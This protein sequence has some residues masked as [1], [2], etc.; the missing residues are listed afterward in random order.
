MVPRFA[1]IE[2]RIIIQKRSKKVEISTKKVLLTHAKILN[3]E[4]FY[5]T[6]ILDNILTNAIKF[7]HKNKNIYL[8][9]LASK[10][11]VEFIIRDEG[12]GINKDELS[13][14]FKKFVKLSARPTEKESSTGLGFSIVKELVTKLGGEIRVESEW[15][16]G[17][18]FYIII[19]NHNI[20]ATKY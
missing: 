4:K 7:T 17:S 20:L 5:L 16:K 6:R 8:K 14:L 9:I 11:N 18:T 13:K 2:I 1:T 3:T 12:Q 15:E 19:P 10:T